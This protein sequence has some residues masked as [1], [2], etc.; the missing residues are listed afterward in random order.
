MKDIFTHFVHQTSESISL[1]INLNMT[2]SHM[3]IRFQQLIF[4]YAIKA[5]VVYS[6]LKS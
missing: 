3:E 6:F 5:Y 1:K 2:E 4:H